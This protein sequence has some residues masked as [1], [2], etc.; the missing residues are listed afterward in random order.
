MFTVSQLISNQWHYEHGLLMLY[1][2]RHAHSPR[3]CNKDLLNCQLH[4]ISLLC[5]AIPFI[6]R[7]NQL[8]FVPTSHSP[9]SGYRNHEHLAPI[10]LYIHRCTDSNKRRQQDTEETHYHFGRK[11]LQFQLTTDYHS[12]HY[13]PIHLP[14]PRGSIRQ[15]LVP[16]H[17][18]GLNIGL[19]CILM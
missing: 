1:P 5:S 4:A 10:W 15:Q 18:V 3:W 11:R 19:S 17:W 8:F 12:H 13:I 9:F 6:Y 16:H 7:F 2:I 14:L